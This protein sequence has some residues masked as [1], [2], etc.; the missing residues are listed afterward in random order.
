MKNIVYYLLGIS[1]LFNSCDNPVEEVISYDYSIEQ[2]MDCFCSQAGVF[3]KLFITADTV[4]NALRVSDNQQLSYNEFK[5]YKSIN[6]LYNLI[7]ATDT[8]EYI[9]IVTQNN[10]DN[11]PSYVYVDLKPIK[12]N[13]TTFVSVSDADYSYTTRNYVKFN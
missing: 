7:A 4:S 10:E 3:V 12:I 6:D 5:Y 13:D 2:K 11:F 1:I 9:L 8:N